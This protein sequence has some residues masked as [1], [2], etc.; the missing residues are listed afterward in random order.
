MSDP[1]ARPFIPVFGSSVGAE[2][3]A[4]VRS[5]LEAQWMGM[6]PKVKKFE[7]RFGERLDGQGFVMLDSG[8]NS[9]QMAVRLLN[10]P[11]GSEV[12]LPSLTW[13]SCAHAVVLAGCTPVFCD[14]D[15]TTQNVTA[16]NVGPLISEK[17][18]AIMVVHYAGLPVAMEPILDFGLPTIEDAAHAV[19]STLDGRRCGALGTVGIYS[20]NA[21]KNLAS[22][23]GGGLTATDPALVERARRLRYCG[24]GDSGLERS[25]WTDRWWEYE[26]TECYPRF[27]PNDIAASIALAQLAK[28]DA[29][30]ARRK[31]IWDRFQ[32]QFGDLAWLATPNDPGPGER[33][34]YFTYVVRVG[35]GRRDAF[36]RHLYDLGIYTTL[37]YHPLHLNAIYGSSAR[38]PVCERLNEEALSLPLHPGLSEDDLARIVA[39]VQGFGATAQR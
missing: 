24:I 27:L 20:F 35:G 15:L 2:E 8:S 14:V 36:A 5:S 22:C 7:R 32:E 17:T 30:Q 39:A 23:D 29:M 21:I 25:A 16:D 3:V 26:I 37:R 18:A 9:L 31:H 6:G 10:L 38:L 4:E 28:L 12:I 1:A 19:D 33:H 34:S 13:V 11:P